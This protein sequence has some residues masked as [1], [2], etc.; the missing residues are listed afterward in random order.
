MGFTS[1]KK[2]VLDVV[3]FMGAPRKFTDKEGIVN[4]KAYKV[5]KTENVYTQTN[6]KDAQKTIKLIESSKGEIEQLKSVNEIVVAKN[7]NG[8]AAYDHD[9]NRLYVNEKISNSGYIEKYLSS[10]YFVAENATD[11]VKH[12]L[13]HKEHWDVIKRRALTTGKSVDI[14][15]QEMEAPL[16]SYVVNQNNMQPSYIRNFVSENAAGGFEYDKS[17]NELIADVRLQKDKGIEKDKI[18]TGLVEDILK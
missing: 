3:D 6:S 2:E 9:S 8:I 10:D 5:D 18:L 14:V 15:K 12:E 13:Y 1:H 16:R 17:L 4:V 7:L 11:V